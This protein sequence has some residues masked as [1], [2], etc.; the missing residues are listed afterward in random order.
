M[1]T[2]SSPVARARQHEHAPVTRPSFKWNTSRWVKI[3]L[4]VC[5]LP[6]F[7]H[8]LSGDW[9][10]PQAWFVSLSQISI[11]FAASRYIWI[12]NHS[13]FTEREQFTRHEGTAP[14]DKVLAK[15]VVAVTPF[16]VSTL[17]ADAAGLL[18]R[19]S[20]AYPLLQSMIKPELLY[21]EF[22]NHAVAYLTLA[23][24]PL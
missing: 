15:A 6:V 20:T 11:F 17:S 7:L 24:M 13:L 12:H 4:A 8:G 18:I 22:C 19:L 16:L 2:Y 10:W 5:M 1:D 14:F 23:S 9:L 21:K 3:S